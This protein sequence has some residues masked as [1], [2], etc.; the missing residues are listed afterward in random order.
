MSANLLVDSNDFQDQSNLENSEVKITTG[1]VEPEVLGQDIFSQEKE[2]ITR[3]DC[4]VLVDS[5]GN[6]SDEFESTINTENFDMHQYNV[7]KEYVDANLDSRQVLFDVNSL[8]DNCYFSNLLNEYSQFENTSTRDENSDNKN[9][10][11]HEILVLNLNDNDSHVNNAVQSVGKNIS[12]DVYDLAYSINSSPIAAHRVPIWLEGYDSFKKDKVLS[13]LFD[14]VK[15]PCYLNTW[16]QDEIP[17][18]Q[19]SIFRVS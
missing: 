18:N 8:D 10:K 4:E 17:E 9:G 12:S 13:I 3:A 11:E 19:P 16:D 1:V 2:G 5:P 6:T 14:G 7:N 15:I